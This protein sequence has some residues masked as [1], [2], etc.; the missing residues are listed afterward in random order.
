MSLPFF[1][2]RRLSLRSSSGRSQ[3]GIVIAVTGI[4][5]AIVVMLISIAV[6]L[7]FKHEVR[8]KI[9]GFDAQVTVSPLE[10]SAQQ[11]TPLLD[12]DSL[13]P[14]VKSLPI[15]ATVTMTIRQP[16]IIKTPQNFSGAVIKGMDTGFDWKFIR[17]NLVE[18]VVP[19]YQ[20]DS[21]L[22]HVVISRAIASDLN[23]AL[24]DK[25]DAYFLGNNASYRTRRLKIAGI[26]DTHFSEYDKHFIF[27]TLPML[28]Q[29][30][31]LKEGQGTVLEISGLNSDE[32]IDCVQN[33]LVEKLSEEL[34]SGKTSKIY[35]VGNIHES[36]ALYFNWLALL[37][38]NVA[39]ILVLMALLGMLTLVS[40]L[41]IIVLRRVTM[42]G[43]LKA[44]GA[45]DRQIRTTFVIL[46][47][48]ILLSGLIIGNAI[49]LAVIAAQQH[50]K[51]LPLNPD[52]Y[53]LDHVPVMLDIPSILLLNA[54]VTALSFIILILPSA[55]ITTIPPSKAICYE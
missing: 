26:Y 31:N 3:T 4:S 6:M 13:A 29:L 16:A 7:G 34:Y 2:A 36:A 35:S 43:I 23:L 53:Y 19:D 14:A 11:S 51:L 37:D 25:F 12:A 55:I 17:E 5:L 28:S 9:M 46:T 52:A 48:K 22:Y 39:V 42:I 27:S 33:L 15:E 10:S 44:L 21:T 20:A 38:T 8:Q 32:Q 1:L 47:F 45:T 24:G 41:F 18:G 54:T 49:G 30:G 50:F 40:S